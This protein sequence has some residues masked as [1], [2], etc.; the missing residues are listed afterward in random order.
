M[1]ALDYLRFGIFWTVITICSNQVDIILVAKYKIKVFITI[2]IVMRILQL[3]LCVI[4]Y[5]ELGLLGLG[6]S[7]ALLGV[8]HITIMT[9]VVN[10]LYAIRFSSDFIRVALVSLSFVIVSSLTAIIDNKIV[11]YSS[12]TVLIILSL[13]YSYI[14]S[15]SKLGIDIVTIVKQRIKK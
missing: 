6:I 7:Y 13:F 2:S 15:K 4:L 12:A 11:C 9:Y 10:K 14:Q 3:L 8:C 1:P 5:N